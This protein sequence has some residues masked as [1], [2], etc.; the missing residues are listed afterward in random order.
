M[1]EIQAFLFFLGVVETYLAFLSWVSMIA[2]SSC[3]Y[4][5]RPSSSGYGDS[6][7]DYYFDLFGLKGAGPKC[8]ENSDINFDEDDALK[9][10]P[11]FCSVDGFD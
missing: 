9:A 4:I 5:L 6:Y 3:E 8:L 11:T 10:G 7:D 2:C 1:R